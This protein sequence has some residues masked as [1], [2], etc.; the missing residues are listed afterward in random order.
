MTRT[1]KILAG[2]AVTAALTLGACGS[3]DSMPG[4]DMPAASTSGTLSGSMTGMPTAPAPSGGTAAAHNQADITFASSMIPHHQQA[5]EMADMALAQTGN[6]TVKQLA[7]QIKAA[8]DPEIQTM[9]GWLTSWGA[10]PMPSGHDMGGMGMGGMMSEQE[11]ADLKKATGADFDRMWLQMMVKHHQGAVAMAKT[12]L[13][14]G[15][16]PEA[17]ALAQAVIDGQSKEIATMTELLKTL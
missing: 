10:S 1:T 12:Q 8:Q 5:V 14:Q 15:A 3:G 9:T 7:T 17:K 4:H 2:A 6:R 16:Y 13:D 11:M